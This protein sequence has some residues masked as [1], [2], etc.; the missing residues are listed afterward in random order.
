MSKSSNDSMQKSPAVAWLL[1]AGLQLLSVFW[2]ARAAAQETQNPYPPMHRL[3]WQEYAGTLQFWESTYPQWVTLESRGLSGQNMPVYLVRITDRDVADEDKQIC[4]ITTLH[5][6]PERT[7]TSGALTFIEWMLSDD[8]LAAETRRRQIILVMPVVNPVALFHTDRWGNEHGVESYVGRDRKGKAWD[9]ETLTIRNPQ[10]APELMAV[11]SVVDEYQ[12]EIHADFHGTGLQEYRPDQL[13]TRQTYHGQIMTEI[14]GSAY[15]NSAL[16]PWDWRVTEAM[17]DTGNAAG[18]PSDRFEADAQR[19]FWGSEL[20]PLAKKVWPGKPMFYSQH[21]SYAKYHTMLCTQEVAWEQSIVAR[22]KGLLRIGNRVWN[23]ERQPSYPVNRLKHFV[24]HFVTAY[25]NTASERRKSRV[26]LWSQQ[27]QFALGFLYPQTDGR[28][29]LICATTAA[30]KRAVAAA[31]LRE[32]EVN[33][34]EPFAAD[35]HNIRKFLEAGPEIKLALDTPSAQLLAASDSDDVKLENGIGFRLRLPYRAPAEIEVQL[36][37]RSL[38]PSPTDGYETWFADG[39][40]QVHVNVPPAK[41]SE[42]ELYFITCSYTPDEVRP[43]GWMPPAAVQERFATAQADATPA[44]FTDMPYGKHFRQSMDVWLASASTPTPLVFYLHGGGWSAQD[45]TDIH[46]HLDVR[47]FLNAG[48]SVASVN[49]R[50]LQDANAA[51]VSP[52]VQWPLQD[53]ARA[54]QYLRSNAEAWKIDSARIGACGVSAGGCSSLWLALHDEMAEENS[55]DLVARESTRLLCAAGKAPQTS[56]DPQQLKEWIP[57]YEY[58]GSAFGFPGATRPDSFALFLAARD[59]LLPE[60]QRYSPIEHA[61]QDDPPIFMEFPAQ[62]K[63][64]ILGERQTDPTHSA[65]SGLML[66]QRLHA[67]GV[68]SELRYQ[69][70]RKTGSA[71]MQQFLMRQLKGDGLE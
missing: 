38:S 25:G 20:N 32:L 46:Q 18:F 53:A 60:I 26:E 51:E 30:A 55:D 48:I 7:G 54:L 5:C 56:L 13:G 39:F 33:L 8:P 34:H 31:D 44:T 2:V 22:M 52:P 63:A 71:N 45:K 50:L 40:T 14:T 16:R 23:D 10:E 49:Y 9:V 15:S 29:S 70:D 6:G 21:Y 66:Q 28:E 11:L 35:A 65:V 36:N 64:P 57:N 3:T 37:G 43:T 24:G 68:D 1:T 59:S 69:G 12:P 62:D 4:L 47:E 42:T 27:S 67:L 19:T 17:I 41:A 58:G 61:S